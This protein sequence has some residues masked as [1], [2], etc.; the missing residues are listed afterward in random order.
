[1]PRKKMTEATFEQIAQRFRALSD[2]MRLR[3]LFHLGSE[4][5]TVTDIV[6]RTGGSQSNISKH[7]SMLLSH[8][9]VSR[10]RQ[11]TSAFYSITDPSI[12]GL[13]DQVCGGIER[14]L[15]ARRDAFR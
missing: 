5:L 15:T 8:G 9:L 7:L 14:D 6:E 11:G 4:E 3:I 2:P 1:M 10:R 12:F 13:C